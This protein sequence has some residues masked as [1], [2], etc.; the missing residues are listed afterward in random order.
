MTTLE[1]SASSMPTTLR[2]GCSPAT[3]RMARAW[4]ARSQPPLQNAS[5]RPLAARSS[6]DAEYRAGFP[7]QPSA[8]SW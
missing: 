5:S 1:K 8:I 3:P 2:H 4:S 6:R 7:A